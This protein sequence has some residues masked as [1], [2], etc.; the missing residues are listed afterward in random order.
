MSKAGILTLLFFFLMLGKQM[1][2]LIFSIIPAVMIEPHFQSVVLCSHPSIHRRTICFHC[3]SYPYDAIFLFPRW[4]CGMN[5]YNQHLWS[6]QDH[7]WEQWMQDWILNAAKYHDCKSRVEGEKE[8]P[9]YTVGNTERLT[10]IALTE[11]H[12]EPAQSDLY[13]LANVF[14]CVNGSL[15]SQKTITIFSYLVQWISK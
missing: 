9:N 3:S 4:S 1:L 15:L 11:G 10:S 5:A 13:P 8:W 7:S 12:I 14:C 2:F 6:H